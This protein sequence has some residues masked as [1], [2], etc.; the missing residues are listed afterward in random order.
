MQVDFSLFLRFIVFYLCICVSVCLCQC[1]SI[2]IDALGSRK[3]VLDPLEKEL[4]TGGF[5]LL[6]VGVRN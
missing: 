2:S 4:Y 1:M 3:T 6:D 5:K